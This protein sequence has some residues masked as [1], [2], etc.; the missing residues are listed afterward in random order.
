MTK[1]SVTLPW[2]VIVGR[3][4]FFITFRGPQARDLSGRDQKLVRQ[5]A[6]KREKPP[7]LQQIC[8]LDR[9]VAEWRDLRFLLS[10]T[11][12]PSLAPAQ[13]LAKQIWRG[14]G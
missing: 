2:R 4:A 8:H 10:G 13:S 9:S 12:T 7:I 14:R 3:K 11:H 6:L 1:V 5:M